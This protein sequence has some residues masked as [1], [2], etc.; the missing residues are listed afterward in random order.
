[1][2]QRT[3]NKRQQ[4][5]EKHAEKKGV[6]ALARN[7]GNDRESKRGKMIDKGNNK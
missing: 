7:E 2:S 5:K 4:K 6:K 1:M 3:Q